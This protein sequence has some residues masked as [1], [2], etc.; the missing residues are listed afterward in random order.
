M[1]IKYYFFNLKAPFN[2]WKTLNFNKN[3]K[4]QKLIRKNP[5]KTY[6]F[7]FGKNFL[8]GDGF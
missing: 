8:L 7:A 3:A 6:I 1:C 5:V 2:I 4:T